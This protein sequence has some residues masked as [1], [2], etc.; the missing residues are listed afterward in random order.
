MK[1]PA[2]H[3]AI[4]AALFA[5]AACHQPAAQPAA[6]EADA[7]DSDAAT[8]LDVLGKDAEI[9]VPRDIAEVDAGP[10]GPPIRTLLQRPWFPTHTHNLLLDT[11]DSSDNSWGYFFGIVVPTS[12]DLTFQLRPA[13]FYSDSPVGTSQPI[14]IVYPSGA[15]ASNATANLTV[16]PFT[17]SKMPVQAGIWLAVRNDADQL[18]DDPLAQGVTVALLPTDATADKVLLVDDGTPPQVTKSGHWRHYALAAPLALPHGGWFEIAQPAK[19]VHL[20]LTAPEVY[21]V[22]EKASK[23]KAHHQQKAPITDDERAALAVYARH[24]QELQQKLPETHPR[25]TR[26]ER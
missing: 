22:D 4:F 16:A 23:G 6:V 24:L 15:S 9:D 17:G 10:V 25:T 20:W 1:N 14:A 2:H 19:K 5:L 11:L 13:Y 3:A 7:A 8:D 12:V 26:L 18:L 21:P